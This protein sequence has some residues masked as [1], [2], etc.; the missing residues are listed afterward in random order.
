MGVRSGPAVTLERRAASEG[1]EQGGGAGAASLRPAAAGLEGATP[2]PLF[3][4]RRPTPSRPCDARSPR[5]ASAARLQRSHNKAPSNPAGR[6]GGVRAGLWASRR[7]AL[8][9]DRACHAT[10]RSAATSGC[11]AGVRQCALN[12]PRV[13]HRRPSAGPRQRSSPEG[14]RHRRWPGGA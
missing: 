12:R 5:S 3:R 8:R 4:R 9:P 2:T 1:P 7:R 6:R 14:T 13:P 11:S 10:N